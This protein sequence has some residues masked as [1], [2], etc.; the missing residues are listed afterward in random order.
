VERYIGL[1][2][3]AASC[4]LAVISQA[5][6]RLKDFP[7]ETHGQALVEAIRMIHGQKCLVFEEGIQS[8]WHYETL[9]PRF[10]EIVFAGITRSR[11]QEP[12]GERVRGVVQREAAGCAAE[13]EDLLHPDR[14]QGA[15][16]AMV[17]GVQRI[18][19][20]QRGGLATAAPE[21]IALQRPASASLQ[22]VAALT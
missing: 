6:K 22:L 2:V 15:A 7:V 1:D 17:T 13:P 16:R 18:P 3:H 9:S 12:L 8:A 21:A 4:T 11:A 10:D 20:S 14:G 5:G 19:A